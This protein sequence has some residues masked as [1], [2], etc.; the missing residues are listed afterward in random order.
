LQ[1]GGGGKIPPKSF[2]VRAAS[3]PAWTRQKEKKKKHMVQNHAGG[4]TMARWH[5]P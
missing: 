1:H 5:L 4:M 2:L 3:N